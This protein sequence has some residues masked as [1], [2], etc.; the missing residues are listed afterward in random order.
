M[1]CT[2]VKEQIIEGLQ[3]SAAV[4]PTK[5]GTGYLRTIWLRAEA[6]SISVMATDANIEFTG[7]YAAKVSEPGFVGIQGQ[8]FVDLVRRLGSGEFDV[9]LD[10][11]QKN[12]LVRQ[13][14]KKFTLPVSNPE[15]FTQQFTAFPT[16]GSVVW[17]GDF[18]QDILERV[19]FCVGDEGASS[20]D[21]I[22]C[23][24]MKPVGNGRIDICGLNGVRFAMVSLTHDD[25]HALL[26]EQGL[27]VQKNYMLYLRKWLGSDEIELNL[28]DKRLFM[29]AQNGAEMISLPRSTYDY[30]DYTTFLAK[31][32][33]EGVHTLTL[34]RKDALDA[35]GRIMLFSTESERCTYFDLTSSELVMSAQGKDSGSAQENLE[36]QYDGDVPRIA[37]PTKGMTEMLEHFNS[38]VLQ[39]RISSVDGPC[40]ISGKDDPDYTS[41]IMPLKVVET[42]YYTE[43][44]AQ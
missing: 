12:L 39:L 37:F 4:I 6:D 44:E 28:S 27:L 32:G 10:A 18:L 33:G 14:R 25:L 13:G 20:I 24:L 41:I 8:L 42:S 1:K 7:K 21:A 9:E 36:I 2:I 22:S 31:I 30:P 40:G 16:E 11:E 29:R 43:G 35:L 15:W 3:K 26:P 5:T 38:D 19:L 23:L 34:N 17:S